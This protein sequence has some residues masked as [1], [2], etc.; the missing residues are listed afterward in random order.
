MRERIIL[1]YH[2]IGIMIIK[3]EIKNKVT[4]YYVEKEITDENMEKLKN[5]FVKK[6]QINL[7]IDDDTD[8]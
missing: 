6:S 7:I 1:Y 5:T 3:K 2:N 4:I 8:V